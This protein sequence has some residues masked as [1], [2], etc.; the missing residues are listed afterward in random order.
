MKNKSPKEIALNIVNKLNLPVF[1]CMENKRPFTKN[2]FKSATKDPDEVNNFWN[3]F[4]KALIGVPTGK[5]SG[6]FV[7]DIDEGK[8]KSGEDNF[9]NLGLTH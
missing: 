5:I 2:G 4:P 1:P 6:L 8:N 7:I 9:K 3:R